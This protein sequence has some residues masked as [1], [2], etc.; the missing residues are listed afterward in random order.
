M[1]YA[2]LCVPPNRESKTYY[3]KTYNLWSNKWYDKFKQPWF[4]RDTNKYNKCLATSEWGR[5][6]LKVSGE[7]CYKKKKGKDKGKEVCAKFDIGSNTIGKPYEVHTSTAS[8]AGKTQMGL[9]QDM[10]SAILNFETL[11]KRILIGGAIAL[12]LILR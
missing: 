7:Y 4:N 2:G 11:D 8:V 5:P 6:S 9:G 3:K 12:L 1:S 10:G